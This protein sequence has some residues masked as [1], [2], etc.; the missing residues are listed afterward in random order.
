MEKPPVLLWM[1]IY[2]VL[3]ALVYFG[4]VALFGALIFWIEDGSS[5]AMVDM[6][7]FG[8]VSIICLVFG[9][10]H[11]AALVVNRQSWGYAYGMAVIVIGL[12]SCATWPLTIPLLVMWMKPEVKNWFNPA[13]NA[14]NVLR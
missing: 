11:L 10:L 8:F 5:D 12:T 3:L 9:V 4:C 1:K 2:S 7:T 14:T 6:I 13:S